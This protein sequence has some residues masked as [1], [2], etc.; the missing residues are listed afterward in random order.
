MSRRILITGAS[1]G[2]GRALAAE[3]AGS[4][5]TIAL[6]SRRENELGET[7][8]ACRAAGAVE[9]AVFPGDIG[10][11][12]EAERVVRAAEDRFGALDM[13][14]AN[15]GIS[16]HAPAASV[17]LGDVEEIFAVNFHGA[18]ATVLAALPAML[19]RGSGHVVGVSSIAGFRG[20]PGSAAYCSSKAALTTFLEGLRPELKRRGVD[21]SVV[22]PG[23]VRTP[24]TDKNQFPMPFLMSAEK[25]ARLIANGLAAKKRHIAFPLPMAT[26][27]RLV[28]I[29]PARVFDFAMD[30]AIPPF[31]TPPT[32]P[33][34]T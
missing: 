13:V 21:L 7:A 12:G 23:F 1:S 31:P 20:L 17:C 24:L 26:L 6:C 25:A 8:R 16:R 14:I 15:A 3:L 19:K 10:K 11:K 27:M 18:V 30:R 22:S 32:G 33:S 29:L 28:Q 5:A 9:V 34:G 2:I 4:G